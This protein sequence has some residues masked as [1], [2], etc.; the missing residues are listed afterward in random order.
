MLPESCANGEF[1]S[2]RLPSHWQSPD[3]WLSADSG[4]FVLAVAVVLVAAAVGFAVGFA[5]GCVGG[6]ANET[7]MA[8]EKVKEKELRRETVSERVVCAWQSEMGREIEI[9]IEI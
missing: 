4:L 9:V 1:P 2:H 5:L 3:Q 7:E 6:C 8:M